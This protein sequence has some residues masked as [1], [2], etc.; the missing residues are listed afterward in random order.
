M[1]WS[2]EKGSGGVLA[3]WLGGLANPSDEGAAIPF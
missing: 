1:F 2:G 3:A